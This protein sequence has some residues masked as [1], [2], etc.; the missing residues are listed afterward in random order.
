MLH[1]DVAAWIDRVVP[2]GG[3]Q[4]CVVFV[5]LLA[6]VGLLAACSSG[7]APDPSPSPSLTRAKIAADQDGVYVLS[8]MDLLA[9]GLELE[10]VDLNR[11]SLT[12]QGREVPILVSGEGEELSIIFLGQEN[13]GPYSRANMYWLD[14]AGESGMRMAERSV[15]ESLCGDPA[16]SFVETSRAEEDL[17]YAGE[18]PTG[19]EH[20][21]W[22]KLL[23][24]ET[25]VFPVELLDL[26]PGEGALRVSLLGF[27]SDRVSPDHHVSIRLNDCSLGEAW[28][29]GRQRYLLEAAVPASCLREGE[30]LVE[31]EA[32]D[33][34]G[35]RVDIVLADWLEI[36]YP[37]SFFAREETL[38][39]E[40]EAGSFVVEGFSNEPVWLFEVSDP[41]ETAEIAATVEKGE[42]GYTL[43]FC[44]DRASGR[45][46]LAVSQAGLRRPVRIAPVGPVRN[47]R[48][49]DSQ[50]DYIVVAHEDFVEA[51]EP[52]VEWR[53]SQGLTVLVVTATQVY[54]E[55]S[56]GLV[57]PAAIH[58]LLR[59][60]HNNWAKPAPQYV[61]LVGEASYDYRDNLLGANRSLLPTYLVETD[62]SGSTMSDNWFVCLDDED[63]LPDMAVGRLPVQTEE[64]A[65]L[66]VEKIIRYEQEAPPGSWRERILLVADGEDPTFARQSDLL[67]EQSVPSGYQISRVYGDAEEDAQSVLAQALAEGSLIVNYVGHGSIDTWAEDRLFASEQIGSLGND[68]R[69]PMMILMSCLLG[70]FGHPERDAMAEELLL[71]PDGGAVAVFAPSSLTL[72]SD[73]GPLNRALLKALLEGG[74]PTVGLAILEAK[75]SQ[76]WETQAQ[77]DVIETFTLFG[78][79]ALRLADP[80]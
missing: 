80:E 11:I 9:A 16:D 79:P 5:L 72:S 42:W 25:V 36:D 52:L 2:C 12:N 47:L 49:P 67:A 54:D 43:S 50:A 53:R 58:E 34:T 71:A 57:D 64:E 44:D 73:Q 18:V 37:R 6:L 24:P 56:H 41:S 28:W 14:L 40:G 75:R 62:F 13:A 68:G 51:L 29:D 77:R 22:Q 66:V 27:T 32:L 15:S 10:G 33:D 61:L 69:Q 63:V 17:F 8:G 70:F 3:F 38:A 19:E 30:N 45:S 7:V 78:D 20:W 46:Y 1:R 74:Q 60:A 48:D 4:R 55:F 35:A 23:A 65:R 26:A 31:L 76:S 21:Y 59:E 39:F